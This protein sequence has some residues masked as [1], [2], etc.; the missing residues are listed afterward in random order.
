MATFYEISRNYKHDIATIFDH[1]KRST[2]VLSNIRNYC[3]KGDYTISFE[4]APIGVTHGE[5]VVITL[6][7][8][9]GITNVNVRSESLVKEFDCGN[10]RTNVEMIFNNINQ[11]YQ[12]FAASK[13][14]QN[15]TT[16]RKILPIIFAIVA[17]LMC[18]LLVFLLKNLFSGG[19]SAGKC[20]VCDGVGLVSNEGFGYST[21]PYCKGA[22]VPPQ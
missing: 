13:K 10:N 21:C 3:D 12:S 7:Q 20:G 1:A 4:T 9:D 11:K 18:I 6:S 22:G 19:D 5:K 15:T 14:K 17:I 8:I 2:S 16:T